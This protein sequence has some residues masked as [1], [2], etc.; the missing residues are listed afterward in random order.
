[1][2]AMR[3]NDPEDGVDKGS[4]FGSNIKN[5]TTHNTSVYHEKVGSISLDVS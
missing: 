3:A 1:M 5:L 2:R 4:L